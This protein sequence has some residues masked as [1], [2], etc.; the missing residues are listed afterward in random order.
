SYLCPHRNAKI[1]GKAIG[2]DLRRPVSEAPSRNIETFNT[3][4][5]RGRRFSGKQNISIQRR[6]QV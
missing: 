5:D 1:S 4:S 2:N 3:D 6:F